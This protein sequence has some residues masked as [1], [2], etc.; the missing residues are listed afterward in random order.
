MNGSP[1][2]HLQDE[3]SP[4]TTQ[5]TPRQATTSN[6]LANRL[7]NLPVADA[8]IS[9]ENRWCQLG[10][11]IQSTA[12]DVL[13]RVSRQ[14]QDLFDDNDAA[15]N[16]L[17]LEKNQLH[18]AYVDHPAAA[19]KTAFYRSRRLVQQRLREMRDAWMTRNAK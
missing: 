6:K 3:A 10:E 17:L 5:R 4:A 16:A 18:K 9:G 8:D 11:T 19:N 1:P 13:G 14:H 2:R 7:A 12:L 15:I